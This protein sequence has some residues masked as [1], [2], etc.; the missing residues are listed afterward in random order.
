MRISSGRRRIQED[1][2]FS[3]TEIEISV[4]K[5]I[6]SLHIKQLWLSNYL[7]FTSKLLAARWIMLIQRRFIEFFSSQA[8]W[9]Q[10][11]PPKQM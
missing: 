6:L 2:S 5:A 9:K 1:I 11:I 7:P 8:S 4:L 3:K 10:L